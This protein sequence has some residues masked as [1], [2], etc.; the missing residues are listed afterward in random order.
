MISTRKYFSRNSCQQKYI[1]LNKAVV[2]IK[3]HTNISDLPSWTNVLQGDRSVPPRQA[4]W[5]SC[6]G[7][8][9]RWWWSARLT[10]GRRRRRRRRR[11]TAGQWGSSTRPSPSQPSWS[12]GGATA[13]HWDFPRGEVRTQ[14][15]SDQGTTIKLKHQNSHKLV[16]GGWGG[17]EG[18]GMFVC[19]W[20]V[21]VTIPLTFTTVSVFPAKSDSN[22]YLSYNG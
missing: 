14:L 13:P 18:K 3:I 15:C 8:R 5:W 12:T 1:I 20:T 4:A 7:R 11:S 22:R 21:T 9:R 10:G 19:D 17:W 16:A 2:T 6:W